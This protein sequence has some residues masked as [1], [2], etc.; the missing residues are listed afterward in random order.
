MKKLISLLLVSMLVLSLVA[1]DMDYAGKLVGTWSCRK[2]EASETKDSIMDSLE[3]YDEEKALVSTSLYTVKHLVFGEDGTYYFIED[4][5]SVKQCVRD[6]FAGM[7]ADLYEG[8]ASLASCYE[9]D[10]SQLTEEEFYA[11]YSEMYGY[12]TKEEMLDGLAEAIYDYDNFEK[13][14]EGTYKAT[15]KVISFD[16][17]N[18][19]DDG[20]TEYKLEDDRLNIT[21]SDGSEIYYRVN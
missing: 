9:V 3:L 7:F 13:L 12:S 18:D 16:A 2:L 15:S 8:R 20:A 4:A 19:A 14:D 10:V 5:E 17:I 1:C 6:F 11:F 21:Y